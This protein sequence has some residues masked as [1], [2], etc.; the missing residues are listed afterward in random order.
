MESTKQQ[1]SSGVTFLSRERIEA[2]R[3]IREDAVAI[4]GLDAEE[5]LEPL[6][7][8]VRNDSFSPAELL[9]VL[10]GRIGDGTPDVPLAIAAT[11]DVWDEQREARATGALAPRRSSA[12]GDR[13]G[14]GVGRR[15][16]KS[17]P[18]R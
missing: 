5:V 11:L 4:L 6:R 14:R 7:A 12:S 17:T 1:G 16:A 2:L 9:G 3:H 10:A 18:S 13:R 15:D 8:T